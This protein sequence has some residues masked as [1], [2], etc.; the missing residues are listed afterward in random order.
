MVICDEVNDTCHFSPTSCQDYEDQRQGEV[1]SAL[2]QIPVHVGCHRQRKG[3]QAET[4]LAT[5]YNPPFST[6]VLNVLFCVDLSVKELG[7]GK[8]P[9]KA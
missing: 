4:V 8:G 2:L 6:A 1:Q 3:R 9:G 5:R 7:K